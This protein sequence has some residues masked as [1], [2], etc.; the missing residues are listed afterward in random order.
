MRDRTHFDSMGAM[1]ADHPASPDHAVTGSTALLLRRVETM[2]A[3]DW[4]APSLLPDW[5]RKHVL[6]HLALNAEALAGVLH[7]VREDRA[8]TMYSSEEDRNADI[9]RLGAAPEQEV[10]DRLR[11]A[12]RDFDAALA[13][14]PADRGDV[15]VERLPGGRTFAA[16]AVADI[17]L[18][19]VEIHHADLGLGYTWRDWPEGFVRSL[20][21]FLSMRYDVGG[22]FSAYATDLNAEWQFGIGGPT[23][24]GPGA[25]LAWWATGRDPDADLLTSNEGHLPRIEGL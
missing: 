9:D 3:A 19:E 16:G 22:G 24:S 11:A 20:L 10:A 17:R 23:V 2:T 15:L 13:A 21:D 14:L 25:A 8:V 12:C 5:S 4:T 18:R 6:A 7:G 1:P